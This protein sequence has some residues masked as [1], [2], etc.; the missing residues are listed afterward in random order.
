MFGGKILRKS[1]KM[2]PGTMRQAGWS[3]SY[4]ES[5]DIDYDGE[6]TD[7]V[8]DAIVKAFEK[9]NLHVSQDGSSWGALRWPLRDRDIRVD[10]ENR[11]LIVTRGTGLCD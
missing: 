8:C 4:D 5:F 7:D 11:Q 6:L 1:S 10:R 2:V 3:D 9:S